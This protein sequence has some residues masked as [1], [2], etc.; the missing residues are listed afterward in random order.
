M[1]AQARS[2]HVN[3]LKVVDIAQSGGKNLLQH[4]ATIIDLDSNILTVYHK[5]HGT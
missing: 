5:R 1:S 3:V 4:F 2:T